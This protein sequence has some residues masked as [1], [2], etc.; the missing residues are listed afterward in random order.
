MIG[1]PSFLTAAASLKVEIRKVDHDQRLWLFRLRR[2]DQPVEDGERPGDDA[3]RFDEAGDAE[4][5][6]IGEELSSTRHQALTAEAE[7]GGVGLATPNFH[8]EG[9]GIEIA[10]RLPAGNH[11]FVQRLLKSAAVR[12]S[13]LSAD[14]F[15]LAESSFLQLIFER[16]AR[17]PP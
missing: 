3:N 11:D 7:N 10:G 1:T 15:V 12:S 9:A 4:A 2:V 6:I 13:S 5:A 17:C 8:C 14:Q 16:G